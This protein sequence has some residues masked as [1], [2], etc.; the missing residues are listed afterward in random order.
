[1]NILFVDV[2]TTGTDEKVDRIIE[3]SCRLVDF[4]QP[5]GKPPAGEE[6]NV[7]IRQPD[8]ITMSMGALAVNGVSPYNVRDSVCNKD[9]EDEV[10]EKFVGWICDIKRRYKDFAV[11]GHNV[12]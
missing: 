4:D 12:H 1:M 8:I 11:A 3:L 10:F 6:F 2:E 5:E 7:Q 9:E